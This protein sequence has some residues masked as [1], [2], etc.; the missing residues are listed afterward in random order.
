MQVRRMKTIG[1]LGGM[2]NQ[3]TA[4][5]YRLMNAAANQRLGGWHTAELLVRSVDFGNIERLVRAGDWEA[6]GEYLA[7]GAQALERAGAELLICVSNTMHRV[8]PRFTRGLAVPFLHIVDP[9]AQAIR[10]A[11]LGTVGLL[12]TVPTM[13]ADFLKRRYA[14]QF[15]LRVIVP[16]PGEQREIDRI[17]FDELVRGRLLPASRRFYLDAVERLRRADAQ[18]VVLGCTE[19]C[20]LM[21]QDDL[22]GFP[23]FDTTALHA[24][25]AVDLALPP[26]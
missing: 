19:I 18:G 14:E 12:G 16:P 22:P 5:Y 20:L 2:S 11:G 8:A 17:V 15:G 6:A 7:H 13:A 26:G 25:A 10:A 1:V 9:T 24:R 23:V 3:A 21:S 4:E